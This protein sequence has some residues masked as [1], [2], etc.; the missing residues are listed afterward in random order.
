MDKNELR[1]R[2]KKKFAL[3]EQQGQENAYK[4]IVNGAV[5][6]AAGVIHAAVSAHTD[7]EPN[8]NVEAL[9]VSRSCSDRGKASLEAYA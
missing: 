5:G 1:E 2:R 6:G 9:R 3:M 7:C 4:T 8:A